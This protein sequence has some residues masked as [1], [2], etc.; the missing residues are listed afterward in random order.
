MLEIAEI[1]INNR[2]DIV[3]I[4]AESWGSQI[5]VTKGKI[6]SVENLPGFV[7]VENDKIKGLITYW[8]E[9]GE[10]EIVSLESFSENHGIGTMLIERVI[11]K[12]KEYK[13]HR[14]WLITTNDNTHAIRFYQKRGFDFTAIYLN[15]I[16]D[17]RKIKPQIP[18]FGFDHIPLRHEIE[19]DKVI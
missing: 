17:S 7:V 2:E 3:K 12:A 10:C 4:I 9:N 18:E 8:I 1:G 19:F 16:K 13:C 14:I 6:H 5:I 15:S 11:E